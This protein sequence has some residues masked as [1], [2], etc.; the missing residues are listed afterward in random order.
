MTPREKKILVVAGV[1]VTLLLVLAATL[2]FGYMSAQTANARADERIKAEAENRAR[3]EAADNERHKETDKKLADLEDQ[4]KQ[5]ASAAEIIAMLRAS[6]PPNSAAPTI[7]IP[8]A[9]TTPDPKTGKLPDAPSAQLLFEGD[10]LTALRNREIACRQCE[11]KRDDLAN[12]VK[13]RDA[14]IASL[15]ESLRV[16]EKA[17]KKSKWKKAAEIS[18]K[19]AIFA[20]GVLLGRATS[21]VKVP[22]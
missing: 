21:G 4:K 12:D 17:R 8:P 11:V 22:R 3:I 14:D 2:A 6:M 13:S 7:I 9:S 19:G 5:P 16:S 15:K 20:G 1:A 10:S 18:V